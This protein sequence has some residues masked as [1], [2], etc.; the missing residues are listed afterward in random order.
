M[1]SVLC[2]IESLGSGGAERQ[3]C[4]LAVLLKSKG[5]DVCLKYY[6][7]T[8]FYKPL[9]DNEGVDNHFVPELRNKWLRSYRL[10]RIIK[11]GGYDCVITYLT[12][13]NLS[14]C[15]ARMIFK[16][17][18]IVSERNTNQH[19]TLKD[20]LTFNAYR[21][22]D[23]IVSNSY[24]QESYIKRRFSF[25]R[26]K[27]KTIPNFIDSTRFV[28]PIGKT[29]NSVPIVLTLGRF[30]PQK[31]CLNYLKGIKL[32][33]ER[34]GKAIFKWYGKIDNVNP[35]YQEVKKYLEGNDLQDMVTL[36]DQTTNSVEVYG[37]ADVFCLPSIYEG[38][39]NTL[40]EAMSCSLPVLC[41]K[42][43]DNPLIIKE[44]ENGFLF[45]PYDIEDIAKALFKILNTDKYVREA[46]GISNR[47][48]VVEQFGMDTFITQYENIIN[49]TTK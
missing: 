38:C 33:K 15:I 7:K 46:M 5:Y 18:L 14:A 26:E 36:Y 27:V 44:N 20:V 22:S 19:T 17:P 9:L 30:T 13:V 3:L 41:G 39:P 49:K 10:A 34:G 25:L 16:F 2:V 43:C 1:K 42:V 31:N 28:P 4:G 40:V 21:K 11:N 24:S 6:V 23:W 12:S 8:E 45:D 29:N 35:Y 47:K 32:F 37:G 48:K